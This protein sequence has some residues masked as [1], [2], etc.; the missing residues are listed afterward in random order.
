M[1]A[2]MAEKEWKDIKII[3]CDHVDCQVA[4]QGQV[5]YPAEWMPD[6]P[7]RILAQRCSRGMECNL[8]QKA[9]CYWAGTNPDVDPFSE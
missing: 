6:Q 4:L 8:Y 3:Y 2:G 9:V 5:V 1:E 7:P